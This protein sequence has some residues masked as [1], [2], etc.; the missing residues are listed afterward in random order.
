M[1]HPQ[2]LESAIDLFYQ[3]TWVQWSE[4]T[5]PEN[6]RAIL[7]TLVGSEEAAKDVLERAQTAEVKS[8]LAGNTEKAFEDGAFGLPY[9]VGELL[10]V[11]R[12]WG[13]GLVLTD[14]T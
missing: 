5:K 7:R 11:V 6:L 8:V 13:C 10:I 4:P 2:S 1:S 14:A 9:F 3:N 12:M